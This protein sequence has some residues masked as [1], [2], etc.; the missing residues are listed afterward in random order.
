MTNI[1]RR[2]LAQILASA[3]AA[4]AVGSVPQRAAAA[5]APAPKQ[6]AFPSDMLWG[7]ATASYQ[8]EGAANED[9]RGPSVW[10]TFS[11]T[12]GKVAGGDTGDV[13]C[14]SYH[15]Y[16]EDVQL[17]KNLG[18][19]GYRMS[20]S[21]SRVFPSGKGKPNP[22]GLDYYDRVIDELLANGIQPYVTLF[23]WDLP[24][25]LPA[26]WR[27]RD[28]A[29][30]YA[31]YAAFMSKR[32]SD[33]VHHFFTINEF[34]CFTDLGYAIGKFAPGLQLPQAEVAQIRHHGVLAHGLGV[35]AIRANA[36]AG[37]QVGL[38]ENAAVFVPVVETPE[39][40]AAAQRAHRERN[41]PFLTAVLE[42]KYIDTYLNFLGGDAPKVE[43]GDMKAIG[44]PIDFVG[45]NVYTPQYVKAD[46]SAGGYSVLPPPKSYPHMASDW[47]TIGPECL[48]WA[49]RNVVDI[50]KVPAI[51]ITENGCSADDALTPEGRI[52]DT[53]RVMYL[54]NHLTHLQRA[55]SE[56]Y[57]VKGYFLWS[58]LDN[59]EWADGYSKRF[60]LH[61]VDFKT[62]ARTPKLSAEWY[63]E[64]IRR[65]AL[66]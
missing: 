34:V 3:A 37:T 14:D 30:A 62:L 5:V 57:P 63:R 60:G 66:V 53:D 1:T 52:E 10:D 13:A 2:E 32:L 47:L 43:S 48:Y 39:H 50:W 29:K 44:S 17:L 24:Q 45:L 9:G 8:I 61:Y 15:R 22:K 38:A 65:N 41:A 19:K 4:G 18:V 11:H 35:Q 42:G 54:R 7:C 64:L 59:F 21:W 12:P 20:I 36:R 51:Y 49:V 6:R 55:T 25:A 58:L 27:S 46:A 33:R 16:K 28:T 56:G 23:H 40:I 26:G 31:D